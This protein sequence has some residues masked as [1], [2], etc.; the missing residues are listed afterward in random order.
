MLPIFALAGLVACG[1]PVE[2]APP[3]PPAPPPPAAEAVVATDFDASYYYNPAGTRDPFQDFVRRA[4]GDTP[5]DRPPLLRWPV[6]KFTLRGVIWETS[7][8][9]AL[10]IDPDGT[11]HPVQ[12]GTEVGRN[13]GKVSDITAKSVTVTEEYQTP[14]GQLVVNPVEIRFA[15]EGKKR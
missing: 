9:R 11:G 12:M 13:F 8:P 15:Q 14:D 7:S 2:E 3:A 10:L 4:S 5:A 1:D 6:E